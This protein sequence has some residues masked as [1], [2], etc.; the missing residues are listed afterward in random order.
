MTRTKI[1]S[2]TRKDFDVQTFRSG[3]P[4]G[5]H[6]NKRDTGVRI[7][8]GASGAIGESRTERSQYRNRVKALER[9]AATREFKSWVRLRGSVV[10]DRMTQAMQRKNLRIDVVEDGRWVEQR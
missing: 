2:L 6:Q 10:E 5:Q 7:K 1:L 8:H 3:G 9:L 4:G